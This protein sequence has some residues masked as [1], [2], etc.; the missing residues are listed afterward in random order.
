MY[1]A[2]LALAEGEGNASEATSTLKAGLEEIEALNNKETSDTKMENA[3]AVATDSNVQAE[4]T[5]KNWDSA[6]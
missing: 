4:I 3:E 1:E 5:A 6:Y 2:A